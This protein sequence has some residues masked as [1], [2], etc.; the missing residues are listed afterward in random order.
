MKSIFA[1]CLFVSL[2]YQSAFTQSKIG[3]GEQ[4]QMSVDLKGTIRLVFGDKDKIFYSSSDDNGATFSKPV[5]IGEVTAM[6]LGMTRGPQIASSREYSIVTAMNKD[7]NITS[8]RLTHKT[9]MW[10]M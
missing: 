6:Q 7:G 5:T 4:P 9:G 3:N 8:L 1:V 10:E 2:S